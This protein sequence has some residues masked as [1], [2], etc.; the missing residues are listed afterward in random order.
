MYSNVCDDV[1]DFKVRLFTKNV[2][3][4]YLENETF[5][6]KIRKI[7]CL[8][9]KFIKCYDMVKNSVSIVFHFLSSSVEE[10]LFVRPFH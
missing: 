4:K 1:T 10:P 6:L 8:F 9:I 7:I 5:F 2:E 3:I